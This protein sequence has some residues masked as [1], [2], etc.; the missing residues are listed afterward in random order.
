M[1]S[2][3]DAELNTTTS[4]SQTNLIGIRNTSFGLKPLTF[5]TK[6]WL[7]LMVGGAVPLVSVTAC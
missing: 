2:A 1:H 3:I 4:G 7:V 6:A 5:S